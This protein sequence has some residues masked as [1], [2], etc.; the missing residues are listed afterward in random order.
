VLGHPV[1][2]GSWEG[3]VIENLLTAAPA[4]ALPWFYRT[5]AG[6][7]ID[8]LIEIR[9]GLN[10]AF[11]IKRSSAP[12]ISRGFRNGCDDVDA[13]RRTV[14]YPGEE[15][16]SLAEGVEAMGLAETVRTLRAS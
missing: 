2:G 8:L 3:F 10:W 7:E 14:V 5:S 1:V 11:E 4:G 6:A 16:F 15:G 13:A 9:A 12:S